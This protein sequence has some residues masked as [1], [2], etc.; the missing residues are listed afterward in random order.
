VHLLEEFEKQNPGEY[1][2]HSGLKKVKNVSRHG[3]G[4]ALHLHLFKCPL[5]YYTVKANLQQNFKK[6]AHDLYLKISFETKVITHG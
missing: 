6:T 1:L 4:M 3:I 5:A 2:S